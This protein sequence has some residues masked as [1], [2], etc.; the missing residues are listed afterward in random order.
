MERN[1]LYG[2][3]AGFTASVTLQ[4]LENIK[5]VLLVPPKELQLSKKFFK[6][7][8]IVAKFLYKD[9]GYRAF[10]RGL[11]PNVTRTAFSS[12]FYFSI[13][14]LCEAYSKKIDETGKSKLVPFMSS[15]T[16]RIFS[17]FVSNPLS[18][19]ETRY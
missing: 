3:V 17:T 8:G 11:I 18:V 6:D 9:E 1:G 14:R 15:L 12:C 13:L 19:I 5:M 10:Y 7:V 16:A 2:S 4:P